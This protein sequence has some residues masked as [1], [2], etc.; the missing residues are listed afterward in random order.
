MSFQLFSHSFPTFTTL[1]TFITLLLQ[2]FK[3]LIHLGVSF[4]N[5]HEVSVFVVQSQQRGKFDAVEWP[6]EILDIPA[7]ME[8]LVFMEIEFLAEVPDL[9]HRLESGHDD[10]NIPELADV[11]GK[12]FCLVTAMVA[13]RAEQHDDDGNSGPKIAICEPTGTV[14]L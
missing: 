11:F 6:E 9:I 2:C 14:F 13:V 1:T 7:N 3:N 10:L 5:G 8:I 12:H 4:E